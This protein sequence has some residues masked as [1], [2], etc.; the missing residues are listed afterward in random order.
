MMTVSQTRELLA[1]SVVHYTKD[2]ITT[3]I[4]YITTVI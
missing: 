3:V 1:S 4:A 2:K